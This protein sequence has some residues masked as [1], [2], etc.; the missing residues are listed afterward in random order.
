MCQL[1]IYYTELFIIFFAICS[2]SKKNENR[3]PLRGYLMEGDFFIGAALGTTLAKLALRY[4]SLVNDPVR[5]N[6]FTSEA[7]LIITS[8][9][10]LGRSG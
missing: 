7:M 9:L 4:K 3:P 5:Q 8:I 1:S 6:H 2:T 10:H